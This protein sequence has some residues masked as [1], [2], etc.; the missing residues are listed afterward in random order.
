MSELAGQLDVLNCGEGD[1]KIVI[2]ENNPIEIERAK[3][4]ITDMLKRGYALFIHGEGDTLI[5]VKRFKPD[6]LTYIIADGPTVAPEPLEEPEAMPEPVQLPKR[7]RG[8]PR[9]REVKAT[10]TKATVVG[11]SAGG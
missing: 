7:G 3:R 11:R 10:E 5:R 2:T 9:T 4:I 1:L 6:T 8:R